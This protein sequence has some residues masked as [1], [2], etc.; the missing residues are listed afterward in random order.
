M[1]LTAGLGGGDDLGLGQPQLVAP[2][3]DVQPGRPA[4]PPA[5]QGVGVEAQRVQQVPKNRIGNRLARLRALRLLYG[6]T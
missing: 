1:F 5:G 6:F 3:L 2:A 4:F